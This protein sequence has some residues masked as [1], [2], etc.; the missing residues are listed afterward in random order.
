MFIMARLVGQELVIGDNVRI[1][2]VGIKEGKVRI[3]I[4]APKD[5]SVHRQEIHDEIKSGIKRI[6]NKDRDNKDQK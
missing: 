6:K 3:G 5:V 1:K 4:D 2:I